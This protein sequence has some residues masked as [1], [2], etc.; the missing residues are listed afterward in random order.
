MGV[1]ETFRTSTA[2]QILATLA[3]LT[4]LQACMNAR[5]SVN[6]A[7][8]ASPTPGATTASPSIVINRINTIAPV[9]GSGGAAGST[10][11]FQIFIDSSRSTGPVTDYCAL[12]T[13]NQTASKACL[14]QFSWTES[15][16]QTSTVIAIPRMVQTSV[17][18]VQGSLVNCPAPKPYDSKEIPDQTVLRISL[19]PAPASSVY[20]VTPAFSYT[21]VTNTTPGSFQ[22]REGHVFDN[23]LRYACH[24]SFWRG[25]TITSKVNKATNSTTNEEIRYPMGTQFCVNKV[26]TASGASAPDGCDQ[27]P[28]GDFSVQAYYYDLYVRDA[29]K[30]SINLYNDR[31]TCPRVNE[32]LIPNSGPGQFW[33]LD[34]NFALAR[35]RTDIFTIGV[36]GISKVSAGAGDPVSGSTT[37]EI[38]G[39]AAAAP[40]AGPDTKSLITSC[41]GF[42]AKVNSDGTCPSMLDSVGK[43]KPT[44][45]LRRYITLYPKIF[46][47]NGDPYK[48]NQPTN[49]IYVVDRP[50]S[51]PAA[52]PKRPYTIRGPKPCPFAF[53]DGKMVT[54]I[55]DGA[56][57]KQIRPSY[58][59]TNNPA[60]NGTNYDGIEL[61]NSDL[62]VG[63]QLSCS[64]T[65][66]LFSKDRT[67]VSLGTVSPFNPAMPRMFIR[68]QNAWSPH[69]EEDLDFKACA[70][71]SEPFLD[72]PLHF[73]KDPTTGNVA[74]CAEAYPTQNDNITAL[75]IK[76]TSNVYYGNVPP[77]TSHVVKHSSSNECVASNSLQSVATLGTTKY[78]LG[79]AGYHPNSLTWDA[80]YI[81][82]L[83][84]KST[85]GSDKTCDRTVVPQ[86]GWGRFP[87]TAT[88]KNVENSISAD[89]TY[90]CT[91]T[92][93]NG[94][95]K[96]GKL[97]PSGGCCGT[98]T[99]VQTGLVAEDKDHPATAHLEPD[100]P[101]MT[102]T[103]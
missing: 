13:A 68:P 55:P 57:P 6:L 23:I 8:T 54:G 90:Q 21:K 11:T 85:I 1:S 17:A 52:D 79:S 33:P 2:V 39:A 83:A 37:C 4:V 26:D 31:Y 50:V 64:A 75:D 65:I 3:S 19:L 62:T 22:D 70:P 60:W 49:T 101:C 72:P 34:R 58:V 99:K 88:A 93:D 20:F 43:V 92:W 95:G 61:P 71:L 56:Y 9:A 63:G 89:T 81:G 45:R 97:T 32:P 94:S 53:F 30:G 47:T 10:T 103:Y 36:V 29:E 18:A 7:T 14:C 67:T 25:M 73:A 69:Y 82:G 59:A 16:S 96:A 12:T 66:T 48:M 40:G 84:I 41:L 42:A 51:Y 86:L 35:D 78:P 98:A 38:G 15:N 74:W 102:P 24:E 77:F 44:Y 46:D 80:A 76:N 5:I 91:V 27:M 100:F 28:P 87:L